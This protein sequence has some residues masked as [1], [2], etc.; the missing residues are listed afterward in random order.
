MMDR[1][2]VDTPGENEQLSLE[3]YAANVE[4]ERAIELLTGTMPVTGLGERNSF[5]R[6]TSYVK[7]G[8]RE[9]VSESDEIVLDRE[10]FLGSGP[11]EGKDW[12][13]LDDTER[14][15]AGNLYSET[16]RWMQ[17]R[18]LRES[19]RYFNQDEKKA[20]KAVHDA[21]IDFNLGEN[22]VMDE[23]YRSALDGELEEYGEDHG[24]AVMDVDGS[25]ETVVYEDSG[26]E[27]R[28]FSDSVFH[29]LDGDEDEMKVEKPGELESL[30]E[31][32][33]EPVYDVDFSDIRTDRVEEH[34]RKMQRRMDRAFGRIGWADMPV[35]EAWD[36]KRDR[37]VGRLRKYDQDRMTHSMFGGSAV[38][39]ALGLGVSPAVGVVYGVAGAVLG[40][41]LS[42]IRQK[43]EA[44]G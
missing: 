14:A 21:Q 44:M 13:E 4:A 20:L 5:R 28:L 26:D 19:D 42:A 3:N 40:A 12:R 25:R 1:E 22:P 43:K 29:A 27:I 8:E 41:D 33:I 9:Q 11:L 16:M 7:D 2:V 6:R 31:E 38:G 23:L 30:E 39:L 24:V 10:L 34:A 32:G 37:G 17:A 36:R 18:E 35:P 15:M